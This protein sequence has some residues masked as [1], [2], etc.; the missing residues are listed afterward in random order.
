MK[1]RNKIAFILFI[2]ACMWMFAGCKGNESV[3]NDGQV[4]ATVAPTEVPGNADATLTETPAAT[5]TSTPVPTATPTPTATPEPTRVPLPV[6]G[7]LTG[8]DAHEL[9]SGMIIGWNLGNTLDSHGDGITFD[10]APSKAVKMWGNEEPTK[11]LFEAVKA[12]GFNTVRIPT[13]WYQHMKYDEAQDK[14]VINED[15]MAYVKQTVDYAYDLNFFVILNV[16][17]EEDWVNIDRF[18]EEAYVTTSKIMADVWGQI[19]ETFAEYDQHLIFEA[20]NEP[21]QTGLGS[22]VEWGS[23]DAVSHKYLND[24]NQVM[25]NTVRG[26][27]SEANK[28]RL[29]ML[30]GYAASS[31]IASVKAIAVPEDGGNIAL[32]VHAYFPYCFAMDTSD[33]AN[34]EFP[35]RSGYGENY[36]ASIT[37]L[38]RQLKQISED[39]GVPV[40]LGE[41]GASDFNNTESRARWATYY[42]TKA[43]EAGIPCV[44]WDN[45]VTFNGTGEAYGLIHRKT[46]TWFP[47]SVPV[48][49]AAM[50]VY[51]QESV[52]PA[53]VEPEKEPFDWAEVVMEEDWVELFRSEE[54]YAL[55]EW[56]NY[57]LSDW[58]PYISEGYDIILLYQSES[59]PYMVLQGGWHKIFASEAG[60]N[61][62]MLRFTY[63]DVLTTMQAENVKVEDMINYFASASQKAMTLYGV[64]AVPAKED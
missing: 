21:R 62:Y 15:W 13:T 36:E 33:M 41:C 12:A 5:A 58:K 45:Q 7:P 24:L 11:E 52:L 1:R 18:T 51:G 47:N 53:Y 27:G 8:Y 14:Y 61:P 59:E 25:V 50:K 46:C 57:C 30:P 64:Y 22:A 43:K 20:M 17:H 48:V 26:Q 49:E 23:G 38:F 44:F 39:K 3:N 6:E 42:L 9:A 29:I 31:Q 63:E 34:H 55:A 28:E 56:G 16:H 32:S 35:G 60:D 40:I 54:G 37:T 10:S 4:T 2:T 19:S